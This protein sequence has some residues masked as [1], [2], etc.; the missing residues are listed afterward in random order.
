MQAEV[1]SYDR[2]WHSI[3]LGNGVV[4]QGRDKSR[5]KLQFYGFPESFAGKTVVDV[6]AWDGFFSFEAERRG[7]RGCSPRTTTAGNTADKVSRWLGGCWARAWK[8]RS[9]RWKT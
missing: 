2:W 6:G 5:E 1:A 7:R 3:D 4:T 9:S 8:I